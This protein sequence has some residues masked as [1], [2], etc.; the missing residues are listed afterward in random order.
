MI[1]K[2]CV[3]F[4]TH[5]KQKAILSEV[6][7]FLFLKNIENSSVLLRK[8]REGCNEHTELYPIENFKNSYSHINCSGENSGKNK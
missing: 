3:L 6:K 8:G 4:N 2:N 7:Y 1:S 5:C